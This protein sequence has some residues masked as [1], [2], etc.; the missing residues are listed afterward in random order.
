MASRLRRVAE[1]GG[2][3]LIVTAVAAGIVGCATVAPVAE[4][5]A[6]RDPALAGLMREVATRPRDAAAHL[7]LAT[8]W[9]RVAQQQGD[10]EYLQL[11]GTG[12]RSALRFAPNDYVANMLAGRRDFEEGRYADAQVRFAT[13]A[14]A[15]PEDATALLA[16][17]SAAYSAGDV[18]LA[19]LAARRTA[20]L[21]PT[22]PEPLRIVAYSHAARGDATSAEAALGRLAQLQPD[23]ESAGVRARVASL[24]RTSAVDALPATTPTAAESTGAD[25]PN[26][27]SIDVAIILSQNTRRTRVGLN[28]LDG[29]RVQFAYSNQRQETR[30]P[31]SPPIEQRTITEAIT[32][33]TLSYNLNIFNQGGQFYQVVARPTLTAY[34]G[35][36]SEFF[37]GRTANIPV[38]GVQVA[39]LE[40]VDIGVSMKV[41]PIEIHPD[42]VKVRIE[43]GRSFASNEPAGTFAEA[44]TVFRQ[45][46]AATAEVRFGESLVLSGLSESVDDAGQNRVPGLGDVPVAGLA[47]NER[48]KLERR[49][50]ALVL[51]TPSR[52][53][54]LPSQPWARPAAVERLLQ[55]WTTVIDPGS[56]ATDVATRLENTWLFQRAAPGDAPLAWRDGG[57]LR[58]FGSLLTSRGL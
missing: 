30:S 12:Y 2:R 37:I 48:S 11:A 19:G 5:A 9:E 46:V 13:A 58:A 42:R 18:A 33:P 27:V 39:T 6:G 32:T 4:V 14:L 29:L 34:R 1:F 40:R 20:Q 16:L 24:L 53:T 25:E 10:D 41:T 3:G 51:L 21:A 45:N 56:N 44:L 36:T 38:S 22:R 49:D 7:A 55:L 57:G 50:A 17:A 8:A 35:E 23:A 47:F 15:E 26:Q 43:T 28:L 52:L 54:A 31:G